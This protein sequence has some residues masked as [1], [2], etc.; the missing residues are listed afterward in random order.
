MAKLTAIESAEEPRDL[1]L[2]VTRSG[3]VADRRTVFCLDPLERFVSAG[4]IAVERSPQ[5]LLLLVAEA[6]AASGRRVPAAQIPNV[7]GSNDRIP[8][9]HVEFDPLDPSELAQI[10]LALVQYG[11][12][13]TIGEPPGSM[14]GS[15]E[16]T[17]RDPRL[18]AH[19]PIAVDPRAHPG[20][21]VY[22]AD[23]AVPISVYAKD[24]RGA[25]PW[26]L[27]RTETVTLADASSAFAIRVDPKLLVTRKMAFLFDQ[28]T[29]RA[30]RARSM[31]QALSR[32]RSPWRKPSY[33]F[34][35]SR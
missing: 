5:G 13:L 29:L 17:C 35:V 9:M 18:T 8:L 2:D 34:H 6:G 11:F 27:Q 23:K 16:R 3:P 19:P 33:L 26:R 7:E 1:A 31:I 21:I 14:A 22:R 32:F 30:S 20:D 12:C 28:G 10:N 15:I 24:A 25:T 4:D